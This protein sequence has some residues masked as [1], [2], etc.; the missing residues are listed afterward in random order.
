MFPAHLI[1]CIVLP[2]GEEPKTRERER[3]S[4]G[5]EVCIRHSK[6]CDTT[7]TDV[8]LAALLCPHPLLHT[9]IRTYIQYQPTFAHAT[10]VHKACTTQ[11]DAYTS[12]ATA[13]DDFISKSDA[14]S[15]TTAMADS[16]DCICRRKPSVSLFLQHTRAGQEEE[17]DD[18][19]GD[20]MQPYHMQK[21]H[22]KSPLYR[23]CQ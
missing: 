8:D 3:E 14:L 2:K 17:K 21:T 18:E 19:E 20:D 11:G 15:S 5:E 16:S 1:S 12:T 9:Y 23:Y 22:Q 6:K 10:A 13:Y 4:K 7:Q